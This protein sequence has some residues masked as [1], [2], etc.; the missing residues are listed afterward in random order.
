MVPHSEHRLP[1]LLFGEITLK[2]V[3]PGPAPYA[4]GTHAVLVLLLYVAAFAG[5]SAW[6]TRNRDIT[7]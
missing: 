6:L 5:L 1:G 4:D 2:G 7:A 3:Q